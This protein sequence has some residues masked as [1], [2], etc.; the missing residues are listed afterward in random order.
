VRAEAVPCRI[1]KGKIQALV[2]FIFYGNMSTDQQ[3]TD[4]RATLQPDILKS[5]LNIQNNLF[6]LKVNL[7]AKSL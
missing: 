4:Q 5:S 3:D 6:K 7:N 1:V 2:S